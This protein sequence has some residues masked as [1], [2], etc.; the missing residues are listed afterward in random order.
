MN[1]ADLGTDISVN[2]VY[3]PD[4][5]L[6]HNDPKEIR[7]TF[8]VEPENEAK[9]PGGEQQLKQYL[10]DNLMNKI[11]GANLKKYQLT[12]AIFTIDEKGNVN[13]PQIFWTSEDEK[14]DKLLLESIC[15]MPSWKPAEYSNGVK[16]KQEFALTVGD[17][18]SCVVNLLNIRPH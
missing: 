15:N 4:N 2:V 8:T 7:F 16:V 13:D 3:M 18:K 12:V 5:T 9:Y 17:M 6:T 11:S 10:K 14:I 1:T